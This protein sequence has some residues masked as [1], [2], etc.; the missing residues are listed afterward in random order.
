MPQFAH[1]PLILKSEG[2]G[3]MSKRD[4]GALI[5]EYQEKNFMPEAVRNYLCML[6]WNPKNGKEVMPI[7]EIIELFDF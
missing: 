2:Q 1:I 5:E 3:K 7:E 6:G 4:R